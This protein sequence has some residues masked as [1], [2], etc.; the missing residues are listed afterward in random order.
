MRLDHPNTTLQDFF[1]SLL[2][3]ENNGAAQ[4]EI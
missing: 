2:L 3:L 1:G 4:S